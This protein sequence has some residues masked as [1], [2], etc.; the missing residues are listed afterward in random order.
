MLQRLLPPANEVCEGYIFT[1]VCHSVCIRCLDTGLGGGVST[2]A[3]W[4]GFL[5]RTRGGVSVQVQ[6][7]SRPAPGRGVQAQAWGLGVFQHVV[8]QT[9]IR[10]TATAVGGINPTGMY[11]CSLG[12]WFADE[13]VCYELFINNQSIQEIVQLGFYT[14]FASNYLASKYLTKAC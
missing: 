10:D 1:A 7:V 3:Q 5:P 4:E 6:G 8:R 14:H 12:F 2:Q 9:P 11:S 13:F